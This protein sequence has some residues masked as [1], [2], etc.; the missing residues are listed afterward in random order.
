MWRCLRAS[1]QTSPTTE[2]GSVTLLPLDRRRDTRC[3]VQRTRTSPRILISLSYT[4][5]SSIPSGVRISSPFLSPP[6]VSLR[7]LSLSL[8][9]SLFYLSIEYTR[10]DFP[11]VRRFGESPESPAR[12]PSTHT[13]ASLH[14][15]LFQTHRSEHS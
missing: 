1:A 3:F 15:T 11:C 9:H 4:C 7:S 10:L 8:S 14:R 2:S 6:L 12:T 13:S 5:S